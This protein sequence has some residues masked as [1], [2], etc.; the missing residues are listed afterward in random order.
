VRFPW[1]KK[2]DF[3]TAEERQQILDAI[4]KAEQRTSGEV[5]L[6][7]ES[8]CR[9]VDPVE[10][11]KEIFLQ[12]G[13]NQTALHNATLIYIAIDDHQAAILGDEGIHKKVGIEYWQKE[14]AKM[15]MQFRNHHLVDGLCMVISDIGEALTEHFPYNSDTDKN[16]LPDEIVFG[17]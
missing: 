10:R 1:Q 9:Y 8:K 14:V 5:R 15:L 4:Q 3:F 6:F 2:K 12:L 16:E 7:V 11:A 13:M 17:R